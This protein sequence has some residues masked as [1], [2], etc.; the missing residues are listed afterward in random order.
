MWIR[1]PFGNT[2]YGRE[3]AGSA[4][5]TDPEQRWEGFFFTRAGLAAARFDVP[6]NG[7][8]RVYGGSLF[9]P[10]VPGQEGPF[11]EWSADDHGKNPSGRPRVNEVAFSAPAQTPPEPPS[12][13]ADRRLELDPRLPQIKDDTRAELQAARATYLAW[14]G[15]NPR[16]FAAVVQYL[17]AIADNTPMAPPNLRTHKGRGL[18][19]LLQAGAATV[20]RLP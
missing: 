12:Q 5:R 17:A 11:I 20:G 13:P 1:G 10:W 18:V 2:V 15:D 4:P 19:G 3:L 7:I 8:I 6:A 14:A 9:Q 16:E